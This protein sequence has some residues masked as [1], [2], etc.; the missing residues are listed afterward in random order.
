MPFKDEEFDFV[1]E[2]SLCHL[3]EKQVVRGVR[4]LNRVVKTGVVFA[5][6]TSDM[7]PA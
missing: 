5:S 7:A 6:V 2:T 3:G 4:E 1:F